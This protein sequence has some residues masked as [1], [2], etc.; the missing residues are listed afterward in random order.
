MQNKIVGRNDFDTKICNNPI[1]LLIAIKE[2]SLNFQDSQYKMAIIADVIDFFMNTRQKDTESLQEYTQRFKRA[3]D[4]T[5]LHV[6]GPI[7]IKNISNYQQIT[8]KI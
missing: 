2:Y 4:I 6:R 8:K 5:E 1:K 7:V 3:K